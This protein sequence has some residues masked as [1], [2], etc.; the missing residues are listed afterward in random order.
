MS[1]DADPK[2]ARPTIE[3]VA[4]Q[5]PVQAGSASGTVTPA[6]ATPAAAAPAP[7]SSTAPAPAAEF[8]LFDRGLDDLRT[9]LAAAL[10]TLTDKV[11]ATLERAVDDLTSLEVATYTAADLRSTHYDDAAGGFTG[12]AKL[13]AL[14]RIGLDGDAAVVVPTGGAIDPAIWTLHSA[15]VE[16]AQAN[17]TELLKTAASAAATLLGA[18]KPA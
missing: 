9:R 3:A 8:G 16:R 1:G 11:T 12:D 7:G 13:Q 10:G 14:T 4:V 6:A 18:V 2:G 15:M 5:G 17:R